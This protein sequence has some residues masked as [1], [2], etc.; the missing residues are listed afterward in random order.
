[1]ERTTSA[2]LVEPRRIDLQTFELPTIGPDDAL[3][4]VQGTGICGSD[5]APYNGS[6][7][8]DLPPL[9][10]GHEVVG[11]IVSIGRKAAQRWSVREG[12]RVVVEESIPCQ[13]CRLCRTG[14]SHM[15]GPRHTADGLRYGLTPTRLAPHLWGG[16]GEYLYL[17]PRSVVHRISESV[18]VAVAPLFIP[19]SNGI[20]WVGRDG[21]CR[22][23]DTVVIIGPGQQGLGC[24]LGAR[25]AGAGTTI[26]VGTG[27]DTRRLEVAVEL[28]ADYAVRTD[29]GPLSEQIAA[30]TDGE[31]ADVVIDVTTGAP[32]ALGDAVDAAAVGAT[33]VVAGSSG[34]RPAANF[35]PERLVLNEIT[36]KGVHGHDWLSARRAIALIESDEYPLDKLCTHT[37][38][39]SNVDLAL[40]TLG[41]E[42]EPGAIHITVVPD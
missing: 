28:G 8:T 26:V 31:L 23:G 35:V 39:L 22:V 19:I 38:P 14:R 10:L 40:R 21:G 18:P 17:H 15:C 5:W 34:M 11:E 9:I 36:V 37:F 13:H 30:L 33:I 24:V 4:R 25:L 7:M 29:D 20:R 32:G 41:G 12:D 16:F 6:W 1:M 2:V 3:L 27:Q 42:G